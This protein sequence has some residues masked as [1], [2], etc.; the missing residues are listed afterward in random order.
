MA[1]PLDAAKLRR[2]VEAYLGEAAGNQA[3]AAAAAG[4]KGNRKA[5]STTAARLLKRPDVQAMV[6]DV[7]DAKRAAGEIGAV[8]SPAEL[9]AWWSDIVKGVA[10]KVAAGNQTKLQPFT[11]AERLRASE[12]L[13]KSHKMFT[14]DKSKTPNLTQIVVVQLPDDGRPVVDVNPPPE[15]GG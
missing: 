8:M 15:K 11:N 2:F 4:Y 3:A 10:Q 1:R 7:K 5:L 14:E 12:L 6:L 9:Q 13:G